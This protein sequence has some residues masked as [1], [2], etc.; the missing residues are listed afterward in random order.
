MLGAGSMPAVAEPQQRRPVVAGEQRGGVPVRHDGRG[1]YHAVPEPQAVAVAQ[2]AVAAVAA[3]P[4]P[5]A[6]DGRAVRVQA[7]PVPV[8][9]VAEA[10]A[11]PEAQQAS[12]LVLFLLDSGRQGRDQQDDAQL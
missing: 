11:V 9:P 6:D 2:P 10:A 1:G 7:Q 3:E 8:V 4:V 12:L 5:V